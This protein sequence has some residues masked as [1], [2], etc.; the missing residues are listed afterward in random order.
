MRI[1]LVNWQDRTN[2]QA[3]GAE[4][5]LHEIFGRIAARGHEVHLLCSGYDGAEPR[6]V[7]DSIAVHRVSSRY[8]FALKGRAAFRDLVRQLAPDVVVEDVNKIPLYLP[9]LWRGPFVLLVPHLFGTT[10]FSEA[11][12]PMAAA[13]YL[14][15]RPLA[16]VY[17]RCAVQAISNSTRDDLVA[18]GFDP[19]TVKV[20]YPGVDSVRFAPD[21]AVGRAA[22]PALLYVG[23]L[24]RYKLV[25]V[26]IRAL[27]LARR[28]VPGSRLWIAGT[29]DDEGR[30][31]RVAAR[32]GVAD[33]VDFLG[34]VSEDRKVDLY[35]R[36]W[37]VV[38]P[39][40]K[41]GWGI[42]NVEAA[43]CGTP[44]IAAD[45]SALRESVRDGE[46]GYLVP[47]GDVEATAAAFVRIASDPPL[48]ER[49][50]SG[51]RA[52]A[53]TL[54]WERAASETLSHLEAVV[55]GWAGGMES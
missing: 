26:A 18:R 15:E 40:L 3:G 50:G 27:A 21:G 35:R 6:A 11:A 14:A 47:T 22:H 52:F 32:A 46:T 45:N 53:A 34:Y 10:A 25:D 7:V 51:A 33:A 4:V 37:A 17:R 8:G 36:A 2:P 42:T 31:R 20:I 43:A 54:D 19:A 29:G 5:H 12:W 38:L 13:V 16:M 39:S 49:L 28:G 55:S 9:T 1:L 48:R 23:R 24:K 41:E 44:A 30:L